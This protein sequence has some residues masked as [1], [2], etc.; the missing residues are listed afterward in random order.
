MRRICII[1]TTM[2]W[3]LQASAQQPKEVLLLGTFHFDN[4]GLDVAKFENANVLSAK[5]QEEIHEVIQLLKA[6]KPDKIFVEL[7]PEVQGKVDTA[8]MKYKAGKVNLKAN[9]VFQLGYRLAKE[10]DLS[11]VYA[12]DY[13]GADFPYDSLVKVCMAA[14]QF[15]LLGFMKQSIDSIEKSF[16]ASLRTKT[17]KELLLEANTEKA[18]AMQVGGYYHFLQAGDQQNHVGAYLASEWWRRNMII[19]GNILKRLEP[20]DKRILVLFGSGHTALLHEMMK[21]NQQL[22]VIPVSS[23]LK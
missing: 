13:R 1:A 7:P 22:Q 18:R 17:I 2:F 14:K 9:E 11:T 4:P 20:K 12:V 3:L 6:Y 21:Y 16:N 23:V 10:L 15:Q 5:R 19:Y 8:I